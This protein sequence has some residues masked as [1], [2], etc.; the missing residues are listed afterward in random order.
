MVDL[1]RIIGGLSQSGAATGL[2]AGLAGGGIA[3]ALASKKG[4]KTLGKA[5]QVG[6]LAVVGGLAWKAYQ[7]YRDNNQSQQVAAGGAGRGWQDVRQEEFEA[8]TTERAAPGS[9]SMLRAAAGRPPR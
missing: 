4:R 9:R 1:N 3:G 2:A 8:V 7:S 5:A 6:G